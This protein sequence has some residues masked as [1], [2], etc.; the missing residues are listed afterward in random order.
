M[1]KG[2]YKK[3][4]GPASAGLILNIHGPSFQPVLLM[5]S[6]PFSL[7]ADQDNI[8]SIDFK[9]STDLHLFIFLKGGN[10]GHLRHFVIDPDA[11]LVKFNDWLIAN[12]K[13]GKCI[14]IPEDLKVGHLFGDLKVI[15]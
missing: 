13:D 15:I 9:R 2:H 10:T 14:N 5:E 7:L 4:M 12:I 3:L 1:I 6:P 11:W 8:V